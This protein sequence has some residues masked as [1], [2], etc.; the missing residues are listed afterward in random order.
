MCIRDSSYGGDPA[1]GANAEAGRP[2]YPDDF[3]DLCCI[4]GQDALLFDGGLWTPFKAVSYTHLDV[5]KRQ[6][7][8]IYISEYC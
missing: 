5:Y 1:K 8:Y 2:M 7:T 6:Y 4:T 3:I